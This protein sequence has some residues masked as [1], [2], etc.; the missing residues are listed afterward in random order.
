MDGS[1]SIFPEEFVKMKQFIKAVID[2]LSICPSLTHIGIIEFSKHARM[3]R[4]FHLDREEIKR[5]VD[6]VPHTAGF[7]RIDLVFPI[8]L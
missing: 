2:H 5:L 3:E 8:N 6:E 4:S 7:T 1:S